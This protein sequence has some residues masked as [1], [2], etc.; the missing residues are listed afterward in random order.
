ML[1]YKMI[2][3]AVL[4]LFWVSQAIAQPT[5][6]AS[7]KPIQLIAQAVV[8]D[9][10]PVEVLL[11]PGATPHHFTMRPSDMRHLSRAD[12]IIWLGKDAERYLAKPMARQREKVVMV[13]LEGFLEVRDDGYRDPHFW[14]SGRKAIQVAEAI[15]K[16]LMLLDAQAASDY[17]K[18]LA[19]FT[20]SV[21]EQEQAI[22][23]ASTRYQSSNY[24]VYH[25]AYRYFEQ[26]YGLA[27]RA[28]VAVNP[29]VNPGAKHLVELDRIIAEQDVN[30]LLI[31]PESSA[32][33]VKLLTDNSGVR[34]QLIDPMASGVKVSAQG[35]VQF[36]RD[37]TEKINQ[38]IH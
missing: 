9:D 7:I 15:T 18:N 20:E 14:L 2:V 23:A 29:E 34:V 28:V 1:N 37:V 21:A 19:A 38:C 12:M 11:P 24:L 25:D 26:A 5:I 17:E 31:E 16:Q 3:G 6:L 36:L 8:G 33:V 32:S 13:D 10:R 30:C 22:R 4:S 27:H 35:Y